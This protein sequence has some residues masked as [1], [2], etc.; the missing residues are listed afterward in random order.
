M[1]PPTDTLSSGAPLRVAIVDT[2][3]DPAHP[4]VAPVAGGVLLADDG[5]GGVR[6]EDRWVDET[7][8]GTA[9]A[10]IVSRGLRARIELFAVRVLGGGS[11]SSPRVL[12]EA[13]RVDVAEGASVINVS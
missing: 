10:G 1:S 4:D 12:E 13:I 7:G 2:G 9:C 11:W 6:R 8:H 3:I 5:V